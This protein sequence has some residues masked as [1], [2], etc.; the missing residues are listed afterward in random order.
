MKEYKRIWNYMGH[1]RASLIFSLLF[2]FISSGILL[3]TPYYTGKAVDRII[4]KGN[5][6]FKGLLQIIVLLGVLF[7]IS[8]LFQWLV[9]VISTAIAYRV[10]CDLRRDAYR[11]ISRLPLRFFDTHP[12]GDVMSR[13]TNDIDAVSDGL[14]QG[15]TQLFMGVITFLG[16]LVL[17]FSLNLLITL[18]IL[19]ITPLAF[20]L[21]AFIAK[22]SSKMFMAQSR[23]TGELNGYAEEIISGQ[24]VVKAFSLEEDTQRSF[25]KVNEELY[26]FGQKAQW[27]SSL[28]NPSTRLINNIAYIS[29]GV[30]GGVLALNGPVA[31]GGFVLSGTVTVGLIASFL[32]YASQ[33]AKPI[34]DITSVSTQLQAALASLKRIF[35][36]IDE[37]PE[38]EEPEGTPK[39]HVKNGEVTLQNIRF[40]YNP[41]KPLIKNLS[42][43][44]EPD[45]VVAIV[46]STGAGKTTLVNLLMRFYDVD[47]GEIRIDGVPI[48]SV[49]RD[50]LRTSFA[51]VLQDAVLFEGTIRENIAY[52]RPDATLEEVKAVAKSAHI[53]KAIMN[54]KDGYETIVGSGSSD[55]SQGQMQLITIA[56][57]MLMNPQMLILDEATS[58]VDTLTELYI[59]RAFTKMMKGRTCFV[60]AHRLSTIR[61]ADLI[62]VM[63]QGDVVEQGTHEELLQKK[64]VYANL[65]QSQF[66]AS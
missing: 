40:A 45:K 51:M 21:S 25:Q 3:I 22:R 46:G 37:P 38:S 63:E 13:L 32:S 27:Y 60:I 57:A 28:I 11:N 7:L 1:Y 56:R 9:T 64:G 44:V 31:V 24:K 62:L 33:F 12:H 49:T 39:L 15:I 23:V 30:V 17:M 14:L 58:S 10:T 47:S 55:L 59:Q 2:A 34:N 43:T 66:S 16:S 41:E 26:G 20:L 19:I 53:H 48:N 54:L 52:G 8:A 4:G 50:S 42:L 6:N 36:L 5:V 35:I 29:V 61:N 18:L 65:C